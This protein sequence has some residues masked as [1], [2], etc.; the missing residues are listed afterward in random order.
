MKETQVQALCQEDPSPG[1]G[2]GNLFQCSCLGNAWTEESGGLQSMGSRSQTRLNTFA[3]CACI[4]TTLSVHLPSPS[5]SVHK[6]VLCICT[7]IP[8]PL[9]GSLVPFSR[10]HILSLVYNICFSLSDLLHSVSQSLGPSMSAN[11]TV[12]FPFMAE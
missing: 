11:H 2:N 5:L 1:V 3:Q 4:S 9:I 6:F 12:L 8:A 10:F 7:S